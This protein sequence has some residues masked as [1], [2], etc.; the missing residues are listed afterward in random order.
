VLFLSCQKCEHGTVLG[1]SRG[2][3]CALS[4]VDFQQPWVLAE[5]VAVRFQLSLVDGC[6]R[7]TSSAARK[8]V[9]L[10]IGR[11]FRQGFYIACSPER[12]F[13]FC[14]VRRVGRLV[15]IHTCGAGELGFHALPRS[16]YL[17]IFYLSQCGG[18][19]AWCAVCWDF[20]GRQVKKQLVS[21]NFVAT[22]FPVLV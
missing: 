11:V 13:V 18:C 15:A 6:H 4:D 20:F 10:F 9:R 3:Y 21:F 22:H 1:C 5:L 2:A 12:L 16:Y 14:A 19:S 17:V 8:G 7:I